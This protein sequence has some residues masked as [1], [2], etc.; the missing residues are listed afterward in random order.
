MKKL[1]VIVL[2][3]V[4][5]GGVVGYMMY[6]K[7]HR[8]TAAAT[9]D[10][11]VSAPTLFQEFNTDETSANAKYLDKVVKV[12]GTVKSVEADE[13]GNVIMTLDAADEMFGVICT[14]PKEEAANAAIPEAGEVVTVKG[15][16]TGK[17]MDVVLIRCVLVA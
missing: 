14:I 13:A 11:V 9:S 4:A 16:C 10:F 12:Q 15:V 17:L 3:L 8:S 6:N 5:I 7:P 1:I 2:A